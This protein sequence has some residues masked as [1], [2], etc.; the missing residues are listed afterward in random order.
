MLGRL[1]K[2]L[3]LLGYDTAYDNAASDPQLARWAR[4]EHRVLLTRDRQL[5]KRRGL[6]TLLI[7]SEA[8][9]EQAREVLQALP[10]TE[11]GARPRCPVCNQVLRPV[12]ATDVHDEVPPYV[13]RTQ[14]DFQRCTGCGRIYWQGTHYA[15]ISRQI[16]QITE[17]G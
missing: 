6:Q 4:V 17:T 9:E 7:Q 12:E 3:R 13:A 16:E 14:D 1:A 2:W 15:A 11:T 10:L 5:A 8:L